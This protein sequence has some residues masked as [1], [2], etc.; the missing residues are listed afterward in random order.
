VNEKLGRETKPFRQSFQELLERLRREFREPLINK[1]RKTAFDL[2]IQAWV[3]ELGAMSYAESFKIIDLVHLVSSIENRRL[4]DDM[5][6][7]Q[8]MQDVKLKRISERL[9]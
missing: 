7:R 1:N 2:L 8:K 9:D 6:R 3:S 4:I 5:I